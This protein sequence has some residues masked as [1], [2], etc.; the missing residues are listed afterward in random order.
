MRTIC[1]VS[2]HKASIA[3]APVAWN[4]SMARER[5]RSI[6]T[7]ALRYSVGQILPFAMTGEAAIQDPECGSHR[8]QAINGAMVDARI[9][10]GGWILA[11][12]A[13]V[14][15]LAFGAMVPRPGM[16]LA[17]SEATDF[18]CHTMTHGDD[19]TPPSH[20]HRMPD[21]QFCPLCM[22]LATPGIV[23]PSG[24]PS[25]RPPRVAA[26][27]LPGLPPLATGSP[28]PTLLAAQPRGPPV[29]V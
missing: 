17:Q 8:W 27:R 13:L 11:L 4:R 24:S 29:L 15:Q 25:S 6:P 23:M 2:C 12:L 1:C 16:A 20:R 22:S 9:S 10:S 14:A 28:I 21:C 26:F 18:I 3:L 5:S 7:R 19:T